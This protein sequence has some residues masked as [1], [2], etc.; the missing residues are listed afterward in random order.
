Q[1]V[2][3]FGPFQAGA[4]VA[5]VV[6]HQAGDRRKQCEVAAAFFLQTQLTV[7][8]TFTDLLVGHMGASQRRRVERV[9]GELD[10][11]GAPVTERSGYGREMTVAINNHNR[12]RQIQAWGSTNS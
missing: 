8:D 12:L 3:Y 1:I 2:G 6:A 11:F 10:L 7:A 5:Q 4:L 9:V